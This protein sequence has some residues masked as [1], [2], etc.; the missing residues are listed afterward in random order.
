MRHLEFGLPP[1]SELKVPFAFPDI[2]DASKMALALKKSIR[3]DFGVHPI[4]PA[5]LD[6]DGGGIRA[7]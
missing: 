3:R 1:G 6:G 7:L 5:A 4:H 2:A